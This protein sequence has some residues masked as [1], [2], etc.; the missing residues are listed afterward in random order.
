MIVQAIGLS[1]LFMIGKCEE[2]ECP[3]EHIEE[4]ED[5]SLRILL[6]DCK[7]RRSGNPGIQI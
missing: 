3:V 6:R 1:L 7:S 4:Q 5:L 2:Q